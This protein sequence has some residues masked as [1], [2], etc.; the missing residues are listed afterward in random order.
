MNITI[1]GAGNVGTQFAV[2]CAEKN[3]NVTLFS[4]KPNLIQKHLTIINE[5]NIPI[6]SGN[7]KTATNDPQK[8]FKN[9]EL[10]IVTLPAFCMEDIAQKIYPYANENMIILIVPGTGGGEC[11]F[12]K[13]IEKGAVICGLQRVPSVARLVKYGQTVKAVGYRD[14]LF[15]AAIPNERS[16][17]CSKI[18]SDI[19]DISCK[20]LPNYL[21]ITLTPSNPILHTTR[22]KNLF[23]D[24]HNGKIYDKIPLFYEDWNIETSELLL[25]CDDEVQ[26]LCK[27]ISCF[28]LSYVNSL[29]IHYESQNAYALTEKIKSIKGFKGLKSPEK[30]VNGGYIPDLDSRYF[31][32]DFPYGLSILV[33]IAKFF[34]VSASNMI[35]TLNWYY[36][37]VGKQKEFSY[38]KYGIKTKEDFIKFYSI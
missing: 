25:K 18:I 2:H 1:V 16:D 10:I 28:D 12:K 30:I 31:T 15:L 37:L 19:F 21:N 5:Q 4:S 34:D 24:Y 3:H 26:N 32:A 14:Q 22:L 36:Q 17:E 7:I 33:Q 8:A 29:R 13:C 23:G 35:D 38:E 9:A 6:H 20:S 27:K 11:A